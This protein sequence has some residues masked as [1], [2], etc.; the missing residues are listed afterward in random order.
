MIKHLFNKKPYV[1]E[2]TNYNLNE[3]SVKVGKLEIVSNYNKDQKDSDGTNYCS[4][5]NTQIFLDG[6][7]IQMVRKI[8]L[9]IV[10]DGLSKVTIEKYI[11]G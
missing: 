5:L 9:D 6:K 7:E 8:S 2:T 4:G 1:K 11:E 3:L 10:A